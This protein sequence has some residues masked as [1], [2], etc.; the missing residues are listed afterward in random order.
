MRY[1]DLAA[2]TRAIADAMSDVSARLGILDAADV[3]DKLAES[4][5]RP[6]AGGPV[7]PR[8][9]RRPVFEHWVRPQVV[10]E[11]TY[12]TWTED[13]QLRQVS[14]Q[15]QRED[16]PATQVVHLFLIRVN[17]PPRPLPSPGA[18]NPLPF[19]R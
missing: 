3:W 10:V 8:T 4:L 11:G 12:L 15:G 6:G 17:A 14:Y 19:G 7:L 9:G 13:N 5:E 1:R 2:G 18:A 16:K